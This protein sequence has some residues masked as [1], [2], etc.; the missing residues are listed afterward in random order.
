MC[1]RTLSVLSVVLLVLCS[2]F[3][4]AQNADELI[5]QVRDKLLKVQDYRAQAI[6][7]TDV[8]FIRIP[9]SEVD[10]YFERPDKFKIKKEGGIS[11]FPKGGVSIN[12]NSLLSGNKFTAVAAGDANFDNRVLKIVKLLPMDEAS[13]IVLISL[14]IDDRDFLIRKATTTTRDNGTYEMEMDYGKFSNWG[15]PD[16]VLFIFNTKDYKLPKSMTLEYEG[17]IKPPPPKTTKQ[18]KGKIE[19]RYTNYVINKGIDDKVFEET[20][21]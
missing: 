11:I 1:N 7:K 4:S 15:L 18:Q 10:V 5:R 20:K 16:R 6:L 13:E 9:Q 8:P 21:K 12:I 14:Y 3:A 17:G 19:I 2:S